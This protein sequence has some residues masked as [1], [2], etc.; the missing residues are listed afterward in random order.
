MSV[1]KTVFPDEIGENESLRDVITKLNTFYAAQ[2]SPEATAASASS[3]GGGFFSGWGRKKNPAL[4]RV[5]NASSSSELPS[6]GADADG[7]AD[8]PGGGGG[9]A[10]SAPGS[11]G[12]SRHNSATDLTAGVQR[13]QVGRVNTTAF[14]E[15]DDDDFPAPLW[16][17]DPLT[18][19]IVSG[20]ALGSG[21]FGLIFSSESDLFFCLA[22]NMRSRGAYAVMPPKMRKMISWFGFTSSSRS[23][24]LK[25]LKVAASS[26]FR[27][28]HYGWFSS[29]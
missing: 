27:R 18:T 11:R 29:H 6:T 8:A 25:L 21:M 15:T 12:P 10:Q 1:H 17:D 7:D 9:V 5:R 4:N 13:M 24:S 26:A 3:T 19:L 23:S 14:M 20:A 22:S 16:A 2:T 28:L